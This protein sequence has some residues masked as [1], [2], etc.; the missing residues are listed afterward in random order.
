MSFN[1][2][3]NKDCNIAVFYR[4]KHEHEQKEQNFNCW[5]NGAYIYNALIAVAPILNAFSSK[6]EPF[7]Y[8]EKPFSLTAEERKQDELKKYQ[9]MKNRMVELMNTFNANRGKQDG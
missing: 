3:W 6:H 2:Y 4:K 5:L 9:E 1:D 8:L 7:D